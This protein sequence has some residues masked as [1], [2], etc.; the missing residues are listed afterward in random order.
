MMFYCQSEIESDSIC[1]S[2]CEHCKEYYKP[3]KNQNIMT[4]PEF[5]SQMAQATTDDQKKTIIC[6]VLDNIKIDVKSPE[7]K[8]EL[9]NWK[10][11]LL[12]IYD[13]TKPFTKPDS[14]SGPIPYQTV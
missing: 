6:S 2:Q 1:Q 10:K 8:A 14:P 9:K 4:I 13:V 11:E 3:L 12:E 7:W 5:Q